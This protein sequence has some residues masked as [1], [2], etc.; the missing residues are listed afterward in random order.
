MIGNGGFAAGTLYTPP[1]TTVSEK[2][3]GFAAA[4]KAGVEALSAGGRFGLRSAPPLLIE[5]QSV[6]NI[7]P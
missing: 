1:L 5:R 4:V 3:A 2:F 7:N 6:R